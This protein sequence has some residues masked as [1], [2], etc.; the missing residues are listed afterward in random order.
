M[1]KRLYGTRVSNP[2]Q[3]AARAATKSSTA[4]S[5]PGTVEI[6]TDDGSAGYSGFVTD[7]LDGRS[8]RSSPAIAQIRTL[9]PRR[10]VHLTEVM[11]QPLA[12]RLG[13]QRLL[14]RA[15]GAAVVAQLELGQSFRAQ[16]VSMVAVVDRHG[17]PARGS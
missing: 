6:A 2:P 1:D 17:S 12:S 13:G 9:L 11:P 10:E 7:L 15:A 8:K 16:L 5:F 4:T 3:R 14:E